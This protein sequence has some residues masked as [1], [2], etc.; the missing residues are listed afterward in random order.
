MKFAGANVLVGSALSDPSQSAA[1]I[2]LGV[3]AAVGA[4][5]GPGGYMDYLRAAAIGAPIAFPLAPFGCA[6]PLFVAPNC[7][8]NINF[9][10]DYDHRQ[11]MVGGSF[12]RDMHELKL[13]PKN[14]APVFRVETSYEFNKPFNRSSA[15]TPFGEQEFGTPVLALDPS[16]NITESDVWST[17]VGFDYFLWVPFWENQRRSIFTSFQ[18]FNIHTVEPDNL[19]AQAPYAFAN[20]VENQKFATVLWSVDLIEDQLFLEGLTIVDIDNDGLVHRQRADFNFFGDT[21]RPRLEW[22][23]FSGRPERGP[24][25]YFQSSDFIEASITVQF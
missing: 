21:F 8:V 2:P 3:P 15:P 24:A 14:V 16:V 18:F 9:V 11:K 19:L 5:Q 22:M 13:G 6:D 20:V 7:S 25:G 10:L 23:H 12:I 1:V 17:M 4:V